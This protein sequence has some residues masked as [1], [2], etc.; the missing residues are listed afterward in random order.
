MVYV[1]NV[2]DDKYQKQP[3]HVLPQP[4]W[5]IC[6]VICL[7]KKYIIVIHTNFNI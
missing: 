1:K 4:F 6:M 3:V 5:K 7:V 2:F